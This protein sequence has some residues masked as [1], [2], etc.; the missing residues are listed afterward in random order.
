M[1][2]LFSSFFFFSF[3]PLPA[4]SCLV[5]V[6]VGF[7]FLLFFPGTWAYHCTD[8]YVNIYE[9][10]TYFF[11]FFFTQF[12]SHCFTLQVFTSGVLCLSISL[13]AP[14][15]KFIGFFFSRVLL[16]TSALVEPLY[17]AALFSC[18]VSMRLTCLLTRRTCFTCLSVVSFCPWAK[19]KQQHQQ[20][21]VL[22]IALFCHASLLLTLLAFFRVE[23]SCSE[24]CVSVC[25]RE[26]DV[27]FSREAVGANCAF[28]LWKQ[29]FSAHHLWM[30]GLKVPVQ[31]ASRGAS[32]HGCN[33]LTLCAMALFMQF[34]FL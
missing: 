13:G 2:L 32:Q 31:P 20:R 21:C 27:C 34:W 25:V 5:P 10:R 9:Q 33:L 6:R 22:V 30:Y 14:F 4:C 8:S 16:T 1:F 24:P 29:R 26:R 3:F 7:P 12:C 19:L 15:L 17:S 11:L 18:C 23:S 28:V